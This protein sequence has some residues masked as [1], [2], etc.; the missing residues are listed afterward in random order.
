MNPADDGEV[1]DLPSTVMGAMDEGLGLVDDA[2]DLGR[3][4]IHAALRGDLIGAIFD[5]P[6]PYTNLGT[7]FSNFY[8]NNLN[9]LSDGFR[10]LTTN[11]R[12]G[13]FVG[14][15]LSVGQ[16]VWDYSPFGDKSGGSA[17]AS[18]VITDVGI[19]AGTTAAS[20]GSG[21]AA[22]ALLG[23]AVPGIGT[24]VGAG[25]GLLG[26]GFM[27]TPWGRNFRDWTQ[28]KVKNGIDAVTDGAKKLWD[29]AKGL[30]GG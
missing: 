18:E 16:H 7:E 30:F 25:V 13:G 15:G 4:G 11:L 21:V 2:L 5:S 29:G 9:P 1:T 28:T 14:A 12:G 10:S 26:T 3:G 20:I 27:M 6:T 22:G 19:G 24:I 8:S 23:S 17:F